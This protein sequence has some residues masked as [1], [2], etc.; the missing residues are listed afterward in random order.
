MAPAIHRTA[1]T[2][3]KIVP[4][5]VRIEDTIRE[6]LEETPPELV[7]DIFE[8]GLVLAGGGALLRGLSQRLSLAL[9]IPVFVAD[10]PLLAVSHGLAKIL[11]DLDSKRPV[12]STVERGSL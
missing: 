5:V 12:L 3:T 6:T 10:E 7:K 1:P 2:T 4:I 8:Q 9:N 11:E